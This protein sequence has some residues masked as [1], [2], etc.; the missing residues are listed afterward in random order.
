M[1]K[2]SVVATKD[3][4]EKIVVQWLENLQWEGENF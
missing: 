4:G 1:S 3:V 2:V